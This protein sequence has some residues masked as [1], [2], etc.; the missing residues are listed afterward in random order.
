MEKIQNVQ[1][2]VSN[3][4]AVVTIDNPPVNVLNEQVA[5]ELDRIAEELND[6]R[7]VQVVIL[8]GAGNKA[9][10]AGADITEFPELIGAG[11]IK[12]EQ[13]SLRLQKVFE[14]I[15]SINK[16]T[17]A[18]INGLALG[19]GCELS[20]VCDL[21]IMEEQALI[22][23]PEVKLGLFPGAGGTQRLPRLIGEARAKEIM[24]SG[25]PITAKKALEIGLI[26]E[27]APPGKSVEQAIT[28][29]RR[30]TN[31]SMSALSHMKQAI[32]LGVHTDLDKGLSIEAHE[33]G[34]VFQSEEISEGIQAFL[35]KRRANYRY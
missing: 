3:R 12:A 17:I 18:A 4:I 1:V 10:M 22:G 21:R 25:E 6:S 14:K 26:N 28:M 34:K 9:F 33:F 8:T 5:A 11:E 32:N 29:A 15:Y 30:F 19:G 16:P 2:E 20:L 27:I 13:K 7:E 23:L 35:E 31:Y 24:F